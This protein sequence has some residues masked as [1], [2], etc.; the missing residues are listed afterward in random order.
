MKIRGIPSGASRER[1]QVDFAQITERCGEVRKDGWTLH[2]WVVSSQGKKGRMANR[3]LTS[4]IM[5]AK[6]I[7]EGICLVVARSAWRL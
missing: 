5:G 6:T 7:A 3:R 1:R 4:L 2:C